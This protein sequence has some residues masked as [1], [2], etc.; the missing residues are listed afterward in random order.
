MHLVLAAKVRQIAVIA[1]RG[2]SD[3]CADL[4]LVEI[5]SHFRSRRRVAQI[6]AR[7]C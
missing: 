3:S 5:L 2:S 6:G 1:R 4:A 7:E